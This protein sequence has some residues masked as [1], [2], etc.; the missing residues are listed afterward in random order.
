MFFSFLG[1]LLS[2]LQVNVTTIFGGMIFITMLY[3][4]FEQRGVKMPLFVRNCYI[5]ER[6]GKKTHLKL[7]IL[8]DLSSNS[9][10]A[11][12]GKLP[13]SLISRSLTG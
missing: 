7:S 6:K 10:T 8:G 12:M 11:T 5:F 4:D 9:N 1:V 3:E 2:E 13:A